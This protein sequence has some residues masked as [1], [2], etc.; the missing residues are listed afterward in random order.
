LSQQLRERNQSEA[1]REFERN[2][3]RLDAALGPA[4]SKRQEACDED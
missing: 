3:L 4:G 2:R 1:L